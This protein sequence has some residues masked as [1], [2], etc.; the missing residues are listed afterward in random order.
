[1][2]ET[3]YPDLVDL[4]KGA[5]FSLVI[6]TLYYAQLLRYSTAEHLKQLTKS[7]KI[8]TKK[9]LQ[10]LT[11]FGYLEKN[12]EVYTSTTKTLDLL[13]KN[14]YYPKLLPPPATGRGA[15]IYNSD[16][17]VKIIQQP[18]YKAL[19]YPSFEYLIPDGLLILQDGDRYQLNFLEIEAKK[20]KWEEYLEEK[21]AKY[22]RLARDV[23]VFNYWSIY[24]QYLGL[25]CPE[26]EGFK[27]KVLCIGGFYAEWRGWKFIAG[28]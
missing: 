6:L 5:S 24:S 27:F 18:F 23:K 3:D 8:A 28:R 20:P 10:K 13:I 4:T 26:I 15:E 19:L 22:E 16:S 2:L 25:K 1:M 21:R 7:V 14:G 17:L 12:E 11:D 9:K